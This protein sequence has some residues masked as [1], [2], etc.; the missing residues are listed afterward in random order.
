MGQFL[1]CGE[2]GDMP[3]IPTDIVAGTFYYA[4]QNCCLK[5]FDWMCLEN[6]LA[7]KKGFPPSNLLLLLKRAP[8]LLVLNWISSFKNFNDSSNC[9][10]VVLPMILLICP[11]KNLHAYSFSL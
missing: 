1:N 8:E 10:R 3:N 9:Y 6:E 4:E 2:G 5:N 7:W 11:F